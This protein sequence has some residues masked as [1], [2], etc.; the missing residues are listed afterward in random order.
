MSEKGLLSIHADMHQHHGYWILRVTAEKVDAY[1]TGEIT[2][3]IRKSTQMP[4]LDTDI[5][6]VW[7]ALVQLVHLVEANGSIG[8]ISSM[9]EPPLF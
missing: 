9:L 5:D 8:K 2:V 3:G 6:Q 7:V 4:Q 1:G